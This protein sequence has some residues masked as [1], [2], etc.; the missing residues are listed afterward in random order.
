MMVTVS[1]PTRRQELPT[2]LV[3]TL[4]RP[5]PASSGRS[6]G[7]GHHLPLLGWWSAGA[8]G[9]AGAVGLTA[10]PSFLAVAA[11]AVGALGAAGD[12]PCPGGWPLAV[13]FAAHLDHDVG[14]EGG[15]L[16]GAAHPRGQL[17][18]RACPRGEELAV[19]LQERRVQPPGRLPGG[20]AGWQAKAVPPPGVPQRPVGDAQF[21][22]GLVDPNL[23]GAPPRL[24]SG[25]S[26]VVEPRAPGPTVEHLRLGQAVVVEGAPQRLLGHAQLAGGLVDA[27]LIGQ[28]QRLLGRCPV[29]EE[30]GPLRVRGAAAE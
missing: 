18:V 11:A 17:L 2:R 12:R 30:A 27:L 8:V 25:C 28:C 10:L 23:G 16:L 3:R 1:A 4:P 7:I 5:T 6:A 22:A 9:A 26:V 24:L 13:G 20:G 29:V 21:L 14:A 19:E 15:V